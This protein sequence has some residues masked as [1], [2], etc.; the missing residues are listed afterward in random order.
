M[1]NGSWEAGRT[2]RAVVAT[3][4]GKGSVLAPALGPVG[5]A[6]DEI[7]VDTDR[8]GVFH[9][10]DSKL[11]DAV[12]NAAAKARA[13]MAATGA[14]LGLA[15]EGRIGTLPWGPIRPVDREVVVLVDAER[16]T[17]VHGT[18]S[19]SAVVALSVVVTDRTD[20][21]AVAHAADLPTHA[22]LVRPLEEPYV[23]SPEAVHD[24]AALRR[25]VQRC[26]RRSARGQVVV[27]TDHRA[28][29]S[30]SRRRVVAAAAADLAARLRSACPSCE[31]PGWGAMAVT[32]FAAC[33]WCHGSVPVAVHV[34]GCVACPARGTLPVLPPADPR[35][36]P[37]CCPDHAM[38]HR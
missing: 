29:H 4:H 13:G 23:P 26:A 33:R 2:G 15:S 21:A 10:A 8:F 31:A 9:R 18:A 3:R 34:D 27:E 24:L 32:A 19:S 7:D 6:V 38:E 14:T 16:D 37:H 17:V 22:V 35:T 20:L 1:I 12:G 5:L 25:A 36:C 11:V 30:P 28:H